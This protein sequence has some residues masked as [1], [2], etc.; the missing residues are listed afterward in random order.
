M[1]DSVTLAAKVCAATQLAAYGRTPDAYPVVV[2]ILGDREDCWR[3][4]VGCFSVMRPSITPGATVQFGPAYG[5]DPWPGATALGRIATP[6]LAGD[7]PT[8]ASRWR[9]AF[10][11]GIGPDVL[12][13]AVEGAG[14]CLRH[15]LTH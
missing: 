10:D 13:A 4:L 7:R 6:F 11:S 3:F 14:T 8:A 1:T 9:T 2:P 5:G 12:A 15:R